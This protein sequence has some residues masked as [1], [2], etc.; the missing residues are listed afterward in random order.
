[1]INSSSPFISSESNRP[2]NQSQQGSGPERRPAESRGIVTEFGGAEQE[3]ESDVIRG[4][5]ARIDQIH[6]PSP[7]PTQRLDQ[8]N[9]FQVMSSAQLLNR[10]SEM[11]KP[12]GK[13]KA[14]DPKQFFKQ[15]NKP[16]LQ[17]NLYIQPHFQTHIQS[18]TQ[19]IELPPMAV[20]VKTLM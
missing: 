2:L 3:G 6:T 13:Q 5:V 15:I 16:F 14:T 18:R 1:M 12:D 17:Y 4:D 9:G 11:G 19:K 20:N 10:L 7:N 8:G